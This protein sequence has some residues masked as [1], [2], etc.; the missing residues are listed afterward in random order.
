MIAG[1]WDAPIPAKNALRIL[2]ELAGH[3]GRSGRPR[4]HRRRSAVLCCTALEAADAPLTPGGPK[5]P[6]SN[7]GSPTGEVQVRALARYFTSP[8]PPTFDGMPTGCHYND[9]LFRRDP[10]AASQAGPPPGPS[11]RPNGRHARL[12]PLEH[13]TIDDWERLPV[14]GEHAVSSAEWGISLAHGGVVTATMLHSVRLAPAGTSRALGTGS[15]APVRRATHRDPVRCDRHTA[16]HS[17]GGR[18]GR[19]PWRKTLGSRRR[20]GGC[21]ET[22]WPQGRCRRS[23]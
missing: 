20:L 7:P 3:G 15:L 21:C 13:V 19:G 17:D 18:D 5:V 6:G 4:L 10:K 11:R 14:S 8:S 1:A 2:G 23:R 9:V 22:R 12:S 16:L